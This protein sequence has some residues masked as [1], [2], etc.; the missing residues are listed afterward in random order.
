LRPLS[1]DTD[2]E[3]ERILIEGYRKMSPEQRL[4]QVAKLTLLAEEMALA[5]IRRK[6]PDAGERECRLRLASRWLDPDLLREVFGWDPAGMDSD[7]G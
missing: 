3:A 7:A 4:A 6:Y 5:D 2:I 1:R